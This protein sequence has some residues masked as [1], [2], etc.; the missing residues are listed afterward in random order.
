MGVNSNP[1]PTGP[2]NPLWNHER[3]NCTGGITSTG[4]LASWPEILAATDRLDI[5]ALDIGTNDFT[6]AVPSVTQSNIASLISLTRAAF[7]KCW[8]LV[9]TLYGQ[10]GNPTAYIDTGYTAAIAAAVTAA[11][12]SKV[13][14]VTMPIIPSGPSY[15][16]QG[17]NALHLNHNGY[18]TYV[19]PTWL[20]ALNAIGFGP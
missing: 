2:S 10:D 6:D 8:M 20:A 9:S 3:H 18:V 1:Q 19:L 5:L 15:W 16:Q 14:A 11:A 12:D 13:R 4:L 17:G 7:P